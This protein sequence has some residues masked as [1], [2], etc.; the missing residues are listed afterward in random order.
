MLQRG[1]MA[2]ANCHHRKL[3]QAVNFTQS[4]PLLHRIWLIRKNFCK[5]SDPALPTLLQN[6]GLSMENRSNYGMWFPQPT[7]MLCK[8][9]PQNTV[10]L[11][12]STIGR[13]TCSS[14]HKSQMG[15]EKV[16]AQR[17]TCIV[18]HGNICN[19]ELSYVP[20]PS[21]ETW[22]L[23]AKSSHTTLA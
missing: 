18:E 7:C 13:H 2:F 6:Q 17:P 4:C 15:Q 5:G 9:T 12:E 1:W 20:G 8:R 10:N 14:F 23:A 3:I 22:F 21:V 19:W 16:W 11:P